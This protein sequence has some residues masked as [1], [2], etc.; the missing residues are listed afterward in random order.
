M[1]TSDFSRVITLITFIL[2]LNGCKI[3]I[4]TNKTT[5]N[6]IPLNHF[7]ERLKNLKNCLLA[8]KI[9]FN[10][11]KFNYL[12]NNIIVYKQKSTFQCPYYLGCCRGEAQKPNIIY[13]YNEKLFEHEFTHLLGIMPTNHQGIEKLYIC[14]KNGK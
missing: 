9:S 12:Y 1:L 3:F 14:I 8:N 6:I 2:I 7:R 13:L 11:K 10:D 4:C 5:D